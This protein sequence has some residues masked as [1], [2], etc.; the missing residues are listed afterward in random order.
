[1]MARLVRFGKIIDIEG[2]LLL[3]GTGALTAGAA[4]VNPAL[5]L[6][7][8]GSIALGLGIWLAKPRSS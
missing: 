6:V 7:T 2:F 4:L 1:M 8:F 3:A 5:A